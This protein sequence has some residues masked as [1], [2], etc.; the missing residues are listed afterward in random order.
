MYASRAAFNIYCNLINVYNDIIC[1]VFKY[2][3]L[4]FIDQSA[5]VGATH[6]VD[7]GFAIAHHATRLGFGIS[8]G[9]LGVVNQGMTLLSNAGKIFRTTWFAT[10]VT[11]TVVIPFELVF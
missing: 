3:M 5:V 9:A 2:T 6:A 1:N 4:W 11:I 10:G 7:W 8:T